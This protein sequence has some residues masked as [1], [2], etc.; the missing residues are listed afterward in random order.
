M[1]TPGSS[2]V[3]VQV[4]PTPRSLQVQELLPGLERERRAEQWQ[5]LEE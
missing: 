5:M 4:V 1:R 3:L 2:M